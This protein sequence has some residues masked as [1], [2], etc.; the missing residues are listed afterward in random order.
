MDIGAV[1]ETT[2]GGVW[3]IAAV[4]KSEEWQEVKAGNKH[5][6]GPPHAGPTPSARCRNRFEALY[7]EDNLE[8]GIAEE[9]WPK[10]G[11]IAYVK[12]NRKVNFMEGI[13][14]KG[15]ESIGC[16]MPP[17]RSYDPPGLGCSCRIAAVEMGWRNIGKEEIVIDSAAEESVCPKNWA[18]D[19]GTNPAEKRMKFINASGGEMGHYG[20]RT[21]NFRT[22]G[23]S[24]IMS[25]KFQVSDVQKPLAAVRRISEKGNRVVFGPEGNYIENMKTGRKIQMVK[26]GGSYVVPAE[27]LVKEAAG[28]QRQAC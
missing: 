1:S 4:E 9:E 8:E 11:E 3:E 2:V 18:V 13:K 25:L 17:A 15:K 23:E 21:A 7:E 20:E 24:A 28:F 14:V 19:F 10:P 26:R 27:L 12:K 22:I 16:A 6:E 5:W